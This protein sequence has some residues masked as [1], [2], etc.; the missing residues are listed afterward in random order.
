MRKIKFISTIAIILLSI[1]YGCKNNTSNMKT[2]VKVQV[3][4]SDTLFQNNGQLMVVL[5]ENWETNN[6]RIYLCEKEGD[7]WLVNKNIMEGVTGKKGLAWGIGLYQDLSLD[8]LEVYQKKA[9]G[10]NKSPAGIFKT[11]PCYGYADSLPFISSLE[12]FHIQPTFQGVDD[13]S[14]TFYNQIIDIRDLEK[15]P[16]NY[17]NSHEE[18]KRK[19]NLYKWFFRIGHN[20]ENIPS[21]GSLIFFHIWRNNTKGTAGCIAT[22]E[23]NILN[24]LMWLDT[25]KNPLIVILPKNVYEF[26]QKTYGFPLIFEKV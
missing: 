15:S 7:R 10:D 13:P 21:A 5:T 14:S 25:G 24:V 22:S 20:S 12:Y 18:I 16:E 23:E 2:S 9:E 4:T 11:G 19:D 6:C 17:Y 1:I 8:T 3:K 26:C